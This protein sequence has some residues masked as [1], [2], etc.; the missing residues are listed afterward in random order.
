MQRACI[1]VLATFLIASAAKAQDSAPRLLPEFSASLAAIPAAQARAGYRDPSDPQPST[2]TGLIVAGWIATGLGL[3]NL[4]TLP[5]CYADFYPSEAQD[6][7]VTLSAVLAGV[8][9]SLGVPFL[10]IGYNKRADYKAWKKRNG[11]TRHLLRT[12]LAFRDD[13]TLLLYA[14][15]L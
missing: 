1:A 6:T 5:V 10:I 7:C 14:G 4:A 2:G 3:L 13:S 12:Q 11:L 8:G 15:E 9:I